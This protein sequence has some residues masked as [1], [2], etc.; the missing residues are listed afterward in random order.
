MY[1]TVPNSFITF[2]DLVKEK[3][4]AFTKSFDST[5]RNY[6]KELSCKNHM[7][8]FFI[9][10]F[11]ILTPNK[12][13]FNRYKI[14]NV[15]ITQSRLN[16][17]VMKTFKV[18]AFSELQFTRR[19]TLLKLAHPDQTFYTTTTQ[20]AEEIIGTTAADSLC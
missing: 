17:W 2:K 14:L 18:Q 16:N 3:F 15:F 11:Q 7:H 10:S 19:N 13:N 6:N 8:I 12:N 1:Y 9:Y 4:Y 20:R 5:Y